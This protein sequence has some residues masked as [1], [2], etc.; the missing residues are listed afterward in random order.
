[1]QQAQV[2][3]TAQKGATVRRYCF[4][5]MRAAW[6]HSYSSARFYAKEGIRYQSGRYV[7]Q[8]VVLPYSVNY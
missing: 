3:A 5:N 2:L 6:K 4:T 1:M 7:R 8:N